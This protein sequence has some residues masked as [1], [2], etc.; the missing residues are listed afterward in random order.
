MTNHIP[1]GKITNDTSTNPDIPSEQIESELQ[2][3]SIPFDAEIEAARQQY[4]ECSGKPLCKV[5]AKSVHDLITIHG[6]ETAIKI[7]LTQQK[8]VS[9]EWIWLNA[10]G[11]DKL[12]LHQPREYFI[13]AASKLLQDCTL[14]SEL[15]RLHEAAEA[16]RELQSVDEIILNPINELIRRLLA[17]YKREKLNGKLKKFK[18]KK[19]NV[20]A[21]SIENIG[22]FQLELQ[23]LLES[24]IAA[25]KK[26]QIYEQGMTAFKLQGMITALSQLEVEIGRELNDFDLIDGKS[27]DAIH[28]ITGTSYRH[29]DKGENLATFQKKINE[30]NRYTGE[31]TVIKNAK[32]VKLKFGGGK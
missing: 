23:N 9:L 19:I 32:P 6:R 21:K 26:K 31:T 29:A 1:S 25:K 18:C 13:Y 4:C 11:L 17:G 27:V 20:I 30:K 28:A 22:K 15:M 14:H 8:Q 3:D 12:A 10:D 7:L 5:D 2:L 16:W 24:L